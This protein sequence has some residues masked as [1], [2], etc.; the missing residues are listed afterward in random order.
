MTLKELREY[1]EENA[2]FLDS[3]LSRE[4]YTR[5]QRWVW[6]RPYDGSLDDGDHGNL[7]ESN[8]YSSR[9]YTWE[10]RNYLA[11]CKL[12]KTSD[13]RNVLVMERVEKLFVRVI[14]PGGAVLESKIDKLPEWANELDGKQIGRSRKGELVCFDF[15]NL[16][17]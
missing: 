11:K 4:V 17:D 9:L 12:V 1:L 10:G 8:C 5:N 15:G 13:N 6:K 14:R 3:G 7:I 16:E 2:E